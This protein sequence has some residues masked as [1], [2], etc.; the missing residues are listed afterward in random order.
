M[1][2]EAA[3]GGEL[4]GSDDVDELAMGLRAS[5]RGGRERVKER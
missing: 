4:A 5:R 1:V 2:P 3:P